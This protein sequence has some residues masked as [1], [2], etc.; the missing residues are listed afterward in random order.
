MAIDTL[1]PTTL[2]GIQRLAT[3]LKKAHGLGHRAA[4]DAAARAGRFENYAHAR[5]SLTSITRLPRGFQLYVTACWKDRKH[6]SSGRETVSVP[7]SCNWSGWATEKQ[8][9]RN[10]RLLQFRAAAADHLVSRHE[11]RDQN[12]A[13][14]A[15]CTAARTMVFMDATRLVPSQ[16]HSRAYP[17]S[18]AANMIP[19]EDHSTIWYYPPTR[20]YVIADEPYQDAA[21]ARHDDRGRWLQQHGY[22]FE[23]PMWKGMYNPGGSAR[24][25]LFAAPRKVPLKVLSQALTPGLSCPTPEQW[26]GVSGSMEVDF[27]S[28]MQEQ[29]QAAVKK[30][31]PLMARK[32]AGATVGYVQTFVGPQRRPKAQMSM[33]RHKEIGTLL[34]E[35]LARTA[36]RAGVYKRLDWVR[37][38]LDEWLMREYTP[39]ELPFDEF[40]D[41]YY[42]GPSETRAYALDAKELVVHGARIDHVASLLRQSYPECA[43]VQALL[44]KL[45]LASASLHAWK[46]RE[47]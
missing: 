11:H 28:P 8:L 15:V 12:A 17:G 5:N 24:L 19:G 45:A 14:D 29:G 9:V 30:V 13:R 46:P 34:K 16:S 47:R 27:L 22:M 41:V 10:R 3:R 23:K 38:E 31:A 21:D 7:L 35:V 25:F 43:P 1:V 40:S 26:P 36:L 37:S 2:P 32:T 20:G 42:H 39:A 6:G 33:A 18:S 4:L 44:G